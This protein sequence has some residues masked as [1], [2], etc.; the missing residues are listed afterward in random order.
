MTYCKNA[1]T[2]ESKDTDQLNIEVLRR[3][4]GHQLKNSLTIP[5]ED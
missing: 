1:Q 4:L 3:N 2:D 5:S